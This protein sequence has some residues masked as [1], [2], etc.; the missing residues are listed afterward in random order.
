MQSFQW[1]FSTTDAWLHN[2]SD[3]CALDKFSNPDNIYI[4]LASIKKMTSLL[5]AKSEEEFFD[6]YDESDIRFD[7][8]VAKYVDENTSDDK[9]NFC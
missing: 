5:F 9:D 3:I 6:L 7:F 1:K 4:P 8:D 2:F